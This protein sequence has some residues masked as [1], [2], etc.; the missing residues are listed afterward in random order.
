MGGVTASKL[1]ELPDIESDEKFF[2]FENFGSTC[3]CN[4]VL[5]ALYFCQ[6]FRSSIQKYIPPPLEE[7]QEETLLTCLAELFM[8]IA[9]QK[10]KYGTIPPKKFVN[11]LRKE[12]EL[13]R[14]YM[15]QDAHEF[16]NYVLN[17]IAETLLKEKKRQSPNFGGENDKYISPADR[18]PPTF[19]HEIFEGVLSNETKCMTC[20]SV[21]TRDESFFDLS[22]DIE[23]NSSVTGCLKNFSSSE[24]LCHKD[25]FFCDTCSSL[26][27]AEKRMKIKKLPNVLALHLKRFKM[28]DTYYRKLA[29]RVV[30]PLELRLFN[31]SDDATNPD[32]CYELTGIIIHIGSGPN[33]GHY[34]AIIRTIHG[35]WIV[36]DDDNV[37]LIK[38][39]DIH[40]YF[41]SSLEQSME[42]GY[43]LLYQAKDL[44][45]SLKSGTSTA[46][47]S[48]NGSR[49]S[50]SSSGGSK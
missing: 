3:Y 40:A 5:Q 19:V 17:E 46:S 20:E 6:P 24:I 47:N 42:S 23:Q 38:E 39:K 41:G 16:L 9:S 45:A 10:K 36:F 43:I 44:D 28:I 25:K 26:Q 29:Y 18:P 15:H 21:T 33:Q 34:I 4:S 27:E 49:S 11:K 22:V 12:N 8:K 35:H 13:F 31:T 48:T 50:N 1:S 2:G 30:F 32:R 14:G 37:Q 7:G